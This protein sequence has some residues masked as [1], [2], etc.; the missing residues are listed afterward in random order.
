MIYS[1]PESCFLG[2]C[3]H[4]NFFA[5]LFNSINIQ[6]SFFNF[7]N[8]LHRRISDILL[9]PFF[10]F[11][12][13]VHQRNISTRNIFLAF[14]LVFFRSYFYFIL[15]FASSIFLEIV[16]VGEWDTPTAFG[17]I[18]VCCAFVNVLWK[19]A[20]SNDDKTLFVTRELLVVWHI[21]FYAIPSVAFA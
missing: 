11:S 14:H 19:N 10:L 8:W 5:R 21:I 6:F 2:C 9:W 3:V 7:E 1:A 20:I 13:P 12:L 17:K 18:G 15:T 4:V 16:L